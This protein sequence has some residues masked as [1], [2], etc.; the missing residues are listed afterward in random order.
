M[1]TKTAGELK[2]GDK[3]L[4]RTVYGEDNVLTEM[5]TVSGVEPD[6]E[7]VYVY[8]ENQ[9]SAELFHKDKQFNVN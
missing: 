1:K 8:F 5:R 6:L 9:I 7:M 3:I 2:E 4:I